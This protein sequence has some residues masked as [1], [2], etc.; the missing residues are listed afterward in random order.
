[1]CTLLHCSCSPP[2]VLWHRHTQAHTI[3]PS[4]SHKHSHS[5]RLSHIK[6]T[7]THPPSPSFHTNTHIHTPSSP[8]TPNT[9]RHHLPRP[10]TLYCTVPLLSR[11]LSL[12]VTLRSH[13]SPQHFT[14]PSLL[15]PFVT[16]AAKLSLTTPSPS[17]HC[18]SP[19]PV[20]VTLLYSC[21]QSPPIPSL[22]LHCLLL[23]LV[24]LVQLHCYTHTQP[25]C[26][27]HTVTRAAPAPNTTPPHPP[28]EAAGGG[29]DDLTA[30]ARRGPAR[31]QIGWPRLR[32]TSKPER[33]LQLWW[34]GR[35]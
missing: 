16:H 26:N 10:R 35:N 12:T 17:L 25:L 30:R 22:S 11:G 5:L 4:L 24:T 13:S 19:P 32:G 28:P 20:T 8:P 6:R 33:E 9:L 34:N 31:P 2:P 14:G 7:H 29:A 23:S 21:P 18:P 15:P 1:M 27:T 3:P